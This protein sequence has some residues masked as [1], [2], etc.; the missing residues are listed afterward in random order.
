MFDT[1]ANLNILRLIDND[2]NLMDIN[3]Y[4]LE[5]LKTVSQLDLFGCEIS[6]YADY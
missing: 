2:L 6:N 1:K 5:T 3:G 4:P